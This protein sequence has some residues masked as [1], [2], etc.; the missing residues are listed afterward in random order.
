M[1]YVKS[2]F[3][4]VSLRRT[5]FALTTLVLMMLSMRVSS[6]DKNSTESSGSVNSFLGRW[7]LTL[8]TP[9]REYPSWLGKAGTDGTFPSFWR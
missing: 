7:D 6:E 3:G 4:N 5:G 1:A 2:T 8:K 9:L